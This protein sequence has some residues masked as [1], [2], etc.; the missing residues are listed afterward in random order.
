MREKLIDSLNIFLE[1]HLIPTVI[2][3]VAAI[4]AVLFLPN[5][6]WMIQKIGKHLFFFLIAGLVFLAVQLIIAIFKGIG[7]LR[8]R[9]YINTEYDKIK[10]NEALENLEA[11]LSYVDELPPEDRKLIVQFIQTGNTPIVERGYRMYN[12]SSIHSSQYI[13]KTQNTDGSHLIKLDNRFYQLM[14]AIY[15]E[16]GSISHF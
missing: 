12:P 4:V 8:H 1:K 5:E 2:S 3:V 15:E 16:R 13:I 10:Q 14:K 11:W 9:A 6:Y 7:H